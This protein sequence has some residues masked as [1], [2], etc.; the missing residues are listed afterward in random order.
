MIMFFAILG[1]AS[2]NNTIDAA[3]ITQ[4]GLDINE[5]AWHSTGTIKDYTLTGLDTYGND[6]YVIFGADD[7]SAANQFG[8]PWPTN[9]AASNDNGTTVYQDAAFASGLPGYVSSL[10][11]GADFSTANWGT[12][13]A[14]GDDPRLPAAATVADTYLGAIAGPTDQAVGAQNL[15]TSFTLDSDVPNSIRLGVLFGNINDFFTPTDIS[16]VENGGSGSATISGISMSG[17]QADWAFFDITGAQV[18]DVFD[19]YAT[20]R[21]RPGSTNDRVAIGGLVFDS[22][23][24]VPEPSAFGLA[25]LGLISLAFFGRRKKC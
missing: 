20:V 18:G 1:I 6:G 22:V 4:V 13:Y 11:P 16:I 7:T 8:E 5:P 12:I 14:A 24:A 21:D 19:I 25:F 10:V 3:V 2:T 15:L 23:Q 9:F 17:S